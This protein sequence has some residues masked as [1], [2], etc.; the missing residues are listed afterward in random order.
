MRVLGDTF[1][2][3]T[4]FMLHRNTLS[5]LLVWSAAL[6][7]ALSLLQRRP[8]PNRTI[9]IPSLIMPSLLEARRRAM[10]R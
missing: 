3:G 5:P 1:V 7:I 2:P 4:P 6:T 9:D 10:T 8:S